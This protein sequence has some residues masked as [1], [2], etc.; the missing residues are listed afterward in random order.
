MG[1]ASVL[2]GEPDLEGAGDCARDADL[3]AALAS[4]RCASNPCLLRILE[5][6]SGGI[7][8]SILGVGLGLGPPGLGLGDLIA[9]TDLRAEL[10]NLSGV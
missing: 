2:S 3:D 5:R 9:L 1:T 10:F 8:L 7:D 6:G 4:L